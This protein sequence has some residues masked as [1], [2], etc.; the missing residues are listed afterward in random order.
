MDSETLADNL[1]EQESSADAEN[2]KT[3]AS[4]ETTEESV[5]ESNLVLEEHDQSSQ[6][7]VPADAEQQQMDI[8]ENV[9]LA[10]DVVEEDVA[11]NVPGKTSVVDD[12]E[13]PPVSE[14]IDSEIPNEFVDPEQDS[15]QV[16]MTDTIMDKLEQLPDSFDV[17]PEI[18]TIST[19]QSNDVVVQEPTD[20]L[21]EAA[22]KIE[23]NKWKPKVTAIC[24]AAVLLF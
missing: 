16:E 4:Q 2:T 13:D 8:D 10:T 9:P 3:E 20:I 6:I 22:K 11:L 23:P 18:D 1:L 14:K 24:V 19:I 21:Q 7:E 17:A 12:V 5:E 15:T